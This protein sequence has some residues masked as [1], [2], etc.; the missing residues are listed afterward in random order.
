M[1]YDSIYDDSL[2]SKLHCKFMLTSLRLWNNSY[3]IGSVDNDRRKGKAERRMFLVE[4]L[5]FG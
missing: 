5:F 4:L 1:F 2:W 3:C